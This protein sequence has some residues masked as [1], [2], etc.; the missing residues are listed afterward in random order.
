M[1]ESRWEIPSTWSWASMGDIAQ[2][3]GGGTPFSKDEGNFSENG[4][5]WVTPADLTG[6][7]NAYI[8]RG[9]RDLSVR[10]YKASAAR[11]MPPGTVLF[12]SRA[13]IG[14]CA[15]ASGEISTNQGFK[16]FIL[17]GGIS[18][19]YI[20]HYLLGSVD[21]AESKASGTTFKELS[22][23]RAAELSAPLP[24][25]AEQKWIVAKIDSLSGKSKRARDHLDHIPRLVEKYRQAVLAAAFR[26]DLTREWR[27]AN[28]SD[29]S[30]EH[31]SPEKLFVWSS[32]K[33]LP[34]KKQIHGDVPVIGGNGVSG[35]HNTALIDASTLVIGRVGAQ[36]G[37]VHVSRGPAWIT[38]NAIY[39][40]SIAADIDLDF[41]VLFFRHADL[42]KLAGGSGQPY[43]N[44]PK[45]N[46][47]ELHLPSLGE[48]RAIIA[49]VASMLNWIDR[50][51]SEATGAS[52][53]ISNLDQAVLAKAFHG[54]LVP[55]DPS[56]EPAEE[57][58]QRI[59]AGRAAAPTAKRGRSRS[60]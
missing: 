54:E 24:P 59:A 60:A 45:L 42:N 35:Y 38:D 8:S 47:L 37:N 44:Q 5:A 25:I 2:I 56:D 4:I 17:E 14:Y 3:V 53:L 11:L 19:E 34:T 22:G 40:K 46:E 49:R 58:L 26:G 15:I 43:L 12:S 29:R 6:Y 31:T 21:Y 48:Q 39:A 27:K 28:R 51:A 20:R 41:A 23:S 13:P 18:S 32:G 50:L 36:C 10:G 57:L 52:K 30:W 16:S 33:N 7:E 9:R 1:S 55:Q